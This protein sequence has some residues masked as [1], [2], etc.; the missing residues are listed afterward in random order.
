MLP[1]GVIGP[2]PVKLSDCRACRDG[3][4]K[5]EATTGGIDEA[6]K[7]FINTFHTHF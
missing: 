5:M 2:S 6:H 3:R 7:V 4:R 1:L